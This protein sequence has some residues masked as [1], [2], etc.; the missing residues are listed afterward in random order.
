[1]AILA[2]NNTNTHVLAEFKL[3]T[4]TLDHFKDLTVTTHV[5]L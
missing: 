1:L 3:S 2:S 5:Y 4:Q